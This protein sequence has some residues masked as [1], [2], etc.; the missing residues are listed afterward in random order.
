[1]C[2]QCLARN[3]T[4]DTSLGLG[5]TVVSGPR[6]GL[7]IPQDP[8]T[9]CRWHIDSLARTDVSDPSYKTHPDKDIQHL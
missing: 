8:L 9:D 5:H 4:E 1:M 3:G 6:E 7:T 2:P